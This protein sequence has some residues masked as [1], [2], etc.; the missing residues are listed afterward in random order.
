MPILDI[1]F[2]LSENELLPATLAQK[3][4]EKAGEVFGSAAGGTWVKV[5]PVPAGHYAENT[6]DTA[7]K[8][9]PVFVSILR[10]E[11][12]PQD[13]LHIEAAKLAESL[14]PI[15]NRS[16]ENIHIIYLPDGRGR[17]AFGG[18]LII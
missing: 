10:A 14:A 7:D 5:H 9:Y 3:I 12:P 1:E 6:A 18:K 8:A 11:T 2:V 4:A 15:C 16:P 13:R 17:L